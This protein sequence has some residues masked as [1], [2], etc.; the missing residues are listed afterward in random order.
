MKELDYATPANSGG[1]HNPSVCIDQS[2][3]FRLAGWNG[4]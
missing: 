3:S 4:S 2:I 1:A